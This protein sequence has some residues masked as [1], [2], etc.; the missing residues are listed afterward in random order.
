M[1]CFRGVDVD[2]YDEYNLKDEL[3]NIIIQK[4]KWDLYQQY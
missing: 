4:Y 2:L 1:V 3:Y